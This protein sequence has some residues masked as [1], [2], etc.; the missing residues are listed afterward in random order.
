MERASM[1]RVGRRDVV[2][3][4]A[5]ASVTVALDALFGGFEPAHAQAR[6]LAAPEID[7]L[8]VRVVV[9]SYQI[10]IAPS[11]TRNGVAVERL[12][13]ALG[14]QPPTKALVSEFGLSMHAESRRG[15][16]TRNVLVDFG[17]TANALNNN[18]ELLGID[19]ASF[20]AR[21]EPRP[22]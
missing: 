6:A 2:R 17:F 15:N 11:F 16:E 5:A 7:G 19:P 3:S 14:E 1:G 10:A 8:A 12:G 13:W 22:L 20:D 21:S 9:D 18:L 4:G